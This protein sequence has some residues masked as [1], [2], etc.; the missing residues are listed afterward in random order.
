[1]PLVSIVIP[2]YNA[3]GFITKTLETVLSQTSRDW[4]LIVVDD[5]SADATAETV[6]SF[7]RQ[8]GVRGRCM[9][10]ANRGIAGARNAGIHAATGQYVAFLD[11][12]DV[13]YPQKLERVLAVFERHPDVGVVCH[14]EHV[15]QQGCVV[16][17]NRSGSYPHDLHESLLLNGN[18]LSPS[19]TVVRRS[20]L[21]ETGGFNESAELHTVEDYDLWI[22]LSRVT[23]CYRLNEVL[24]EYVHRPTSAIRNVEVHYQ[25]MI[26]MV[27]GHIRAD[28]GPHPSWANRLRISRSLAALHRSAALAVMKSRQRPEARWGYIAKALR[29]FPFSPGTLFTAGMCAVYPVV[30]LTP[31]M[32][33]AVE[34]CR[35]IKHT[36]SQRILHR[37]L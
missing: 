24:G 18:C 29:T 21:L 28:F 22:R 37:S 9:T 25:N 3:A 26:R 8:H 16:S 33:A 35:Q 23:R 31:L 17:T 6:A 20:V 12:D 36:C 34:H 14:D 15:T 10:Q 13:W 11:H 7:I 30:N 4:E 32:S 1:M 27:E 5:G 19:A 2:A